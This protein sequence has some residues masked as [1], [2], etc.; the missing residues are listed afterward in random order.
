MND[1]TELLS[2]VAVDPIVMRLRRHYSTL[3]PHVKERKTSQ[4]LLEATER[5]TELEDMLFALGAMEQAP[6]FC[7]GYTG[8]GYYQPGKHKCAERHHMLKSDSYA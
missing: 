3:A 2:T 8:P 1:K 5:I 7:C 4:L 6:C